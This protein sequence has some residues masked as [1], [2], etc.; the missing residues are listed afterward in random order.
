MQGLMSS[1]SYKTHVVA[2]RQLRESGVLDEAQLVGC[3]LVYRLVRSFL[4]RK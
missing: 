2:L 1:S 4:C 3:I